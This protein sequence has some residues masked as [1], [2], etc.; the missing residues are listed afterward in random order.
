MLLKQL[1][2]KVSKFKA[3]TISNQQL[4][5]SVRFLGSDNHND[6]F[7]DTQRHR[8]LWEILTTTTYGKKK[9]AEVGIERL[10]DESGFVAAF[11]L[12]DVR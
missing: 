3:Y 11:P 4:T 1:N 12:H 5:V 2:R 8:I 7:E 9:R 6:F 10:M